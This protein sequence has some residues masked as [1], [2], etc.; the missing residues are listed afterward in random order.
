MN[1]FIN[2]L[3]KFIGDKL[4]ADTD[5]V[6]VFTINY[7]YD[8]KK[9]PTTPQIS[10]MELSDS[11]YDESTTFESINDSTIGIQIDIYAQKMMIKDNV[12]NAQQSAII[13]SKKIKTIVN[14]MY[15]DRPNKNILIMRRVGSQP[16]MPLSKGI[17]RSIIRFEFTINEP[18]KKI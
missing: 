5:F 2:W 11:D 15:S 13:I 12:T 8:G 17:Y 1:D 6:D 9:E 10:F 7:A 14:Q 18:Y 4:N 3:M 16:T